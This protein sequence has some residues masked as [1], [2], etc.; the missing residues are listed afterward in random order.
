MSDP[1]P[2]GIAGLFDRWARLVYGARWAVLVLSLLVVGLG[3][4]FAAGAKR[5][6][7]IPHPRRRMK[8]AM[9]SSA[10]SGRSRWGE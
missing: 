3:A 7:V 1:R 9:V 2:T 10:S 8:A 6:T 4:W 5:V